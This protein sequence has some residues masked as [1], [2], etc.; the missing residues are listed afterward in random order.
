MSKTPLRVVIVG[1]V[2]AG[3]Y[4]AHLIK[5][6]RADFHIEIVEQN[7]P[8]A[9]FGFGLAFSERALEFLKNEDSETWAAVQ[10]S[11]EFW[12]DSILYLNGG[13]IR[14]DG[15]GYAG[16]GRLRLLEILHA[17]ARG[18]GMQAVY[19]GKADSAGEPG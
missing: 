7:P 10:P 6:A 3:L 17:R 5:R 12:N 4:R 13:E 8:D 16:I 19:R 11:L 15:M 18:V 1:A 9:T 2:P 14:I